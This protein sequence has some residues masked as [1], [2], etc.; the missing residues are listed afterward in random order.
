MIQIVPRS[1]ASC[2]SDTNVWVCLSFGTDIRQHYYTRTFTPQK[3][4]GTKGLWNKKWEC[5]I[6][7]EKWGEGGE[8]GKGDEG[9]KSTTSE[10]K[11]GTSDFP[12]MQTPDLKHNNFEIYTY[13]D[14]IWIKKGLTFYE[15]NEG[16]SCCMFQ[17]LEHQF[18]KLIFKQ[19]LGIWDQIF[20][21]IWVWNFDWNHQ[22]WKEREGSR[23]VGCR[24]PQPSQRL[25]GVRGA[26]ELC[27]LDPTP[28]WWRQ[29]MFKMSAVHGAS[30]GLFQRAEDRLCRKFKQ[31]ILCYF[32]PIKLSQI[33]LW[34][35][36]CSHNRKWIQTWVNTSSLLKSK[37]LLS[38]KGKNIATRPTLAHDLSQHVSTLQL[39]NMAWQSKMLIAVAR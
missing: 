32:F 31:G 35:V 11:T 5:K 16:L 34:E 17:W 28:D 21:D 38:I 2:I 19:D 30:V 7:K 3:T 27:F 8:Q 37:R 18:K 39:F 14:L 9:P 4:H 6:R 26:W 15:K 23:A 22:Q 1:G 12:E 10:R 20:S 13:V 25:V 33:S 29:G 36:L 24:T